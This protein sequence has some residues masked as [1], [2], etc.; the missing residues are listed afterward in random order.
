MVELTSEEQ[1]DIEKRAAYDRHF[2]QMLAAGQKALDI[3]EHERITQ[4][5]R[6]RQ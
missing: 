4:T 5:R 1:A 6:R 2:E 3:P